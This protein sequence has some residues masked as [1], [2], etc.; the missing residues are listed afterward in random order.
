MIDDVV[1]TTSY[2]VIFIL[3]M[4]DRIQTGIPGKRRRGST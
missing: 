4:T 1:E 3:G 2:V